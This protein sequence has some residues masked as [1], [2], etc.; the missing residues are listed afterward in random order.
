MNY[1][2]PWFDKFKSTQLSTIG[3]PDKTDV[4]ILGDGIS[5]FAAAFWLA[6]EDTSLDISVI[7]SA[8]YEYQ[9]VDPLVM[10]DAYVDT[11]KW[12]K[13]SEY[14]KFNIDLLNM[15]C[16]KLNI[17]FEHCGG[18]RISDQ[19]RFEACAKGLG[20]KLFSPLE[21]MPSKYIAEGMFVPNE[22]QVHPGKLLFILIS[23]VLKH[24]VHFYKSTTITSLKRARG[25]YYLTT[26]TGKTIRAKHLI[27]TDPFYALTL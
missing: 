7:E 5:A 6:C 16:K 4:V 26:R 25:Y 18:M 24:G 10:F 20:A 23:N 12:N 27:V 14:C 21:I 9:A 13:V 3:L 8:R 1:N 19:P 17:P 15:F 11:Q 22:I 2:A